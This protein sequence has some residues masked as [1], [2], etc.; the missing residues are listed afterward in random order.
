MAQDRVTLTVPARNEFARTVRMTAS[1]LV[2]RMG[3]T[4]DDVDDVKMAAEEA[5]VYAVDTHP[6]DADVRFDFLID[7]ESLEILVTLGSEPDVSDEEVERQ[8]SY[9][10][11]I[12]QSVC[13]SYELTSNAEGH[14]CL[15]LFK[16]A[17]NADDA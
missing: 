17:G 6:D 9:A 11:F 2:S 12:L 8:T 14:Q 5:F 1:A 13:D 3:M 10:S 4:Y 7:D 16:R 15:R